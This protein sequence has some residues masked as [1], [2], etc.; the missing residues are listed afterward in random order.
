MTPWPTYEGKPILQRMTPPP[1]TSCAG[2]AGAFR[3]GGEAVTR[4]GR[5]WYH[6]A[7]NG[8]CESIKRPKE[9]RL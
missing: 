3:A 5:N 9:A 8:G 1:G 7:A 4:D 6:D 2:C